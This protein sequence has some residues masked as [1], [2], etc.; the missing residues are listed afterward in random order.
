MNVGERDGCR[1]APHVILFCN[2]KYFLHIHY[3]KKRP[4]LKIFIN[5]VV[6]KE[7]CSIKYLGVIIDNKLSW[8][9]HIEYIR[10]DLLIA[11]INV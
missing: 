6:V 2:G 11:A 10:F 7:K 5:N 1:Y 3:G 9:A 4:S 8:K